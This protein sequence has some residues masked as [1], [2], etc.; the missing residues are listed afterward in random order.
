MENKITEKMHTETHPCSQKTAICSPWKACNKLHAQSKHS[1]LFHMSSWPSWTRC[2]QAVRIWSG[3]CVSRFNSAYVAKPCG[4][5]MI[6]SFSQQLCG[7][8]LSL[9]PLPPSRALFIDWP[10]FHLSTSSLFSLLCLHLF[11]LAFKVSLFK[12]Y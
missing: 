4:D 3:S 10:S 12:D 5:T 6:L 8:F 11:S 2:P 9:W 1:A 7:Q